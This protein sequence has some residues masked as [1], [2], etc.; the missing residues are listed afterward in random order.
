MQVMIREAKRKDQEYKRYSTMDFGTYLSVFSA[1]N[2]FP[3]VQAIVEESLEDLENEDDDGDLQMK[4][5]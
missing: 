2:I 4:P 1:L 5:M 3:E